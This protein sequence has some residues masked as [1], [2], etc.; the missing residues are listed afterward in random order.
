[1]LESTRQGLQEREEQLASLEE[2]RG[3]AAGAVTLARRALEDIEARAEEQRQVLVELERL[4]EEQRAFAA[5]VAERDVAGVGFAASADRLLADMEALEA[6]RSALANA[7]RTA[8]ERSRNLD[9]FVIPDEPEIVQSAWSRLTERVGSGLQE[10]LD[11]ELMTAA[12]RSPM[13]T[14]IEKL[15][16]HLQAAARERRSALRRESMKLRWRQSNPGDH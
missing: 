6:A 16:A 11:D 9:D 8:L 12:A 3:Q 15:P 5:V 7:Q 13:G 1:V 4:E 2:L 10:A 14:D